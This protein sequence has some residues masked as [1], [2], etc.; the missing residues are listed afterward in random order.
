MQIPDPADE[1]T[2]AVKTEAAVVYISKK[3]KRGKKRLFLG[4]VQ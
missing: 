2:Q 3:K 1:T 4:F